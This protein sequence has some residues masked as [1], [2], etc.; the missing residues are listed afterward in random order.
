M[1]MELK[2]K[3]K[4]E[5]AAY[6][7][8]HV[9]KFKKYGGSAH[10]YCLS[11]QISRSTFQNWERKLRTAKTSCFVPVKVAAVSIPAESLRTPSSSRSLLPDA[12]WV[13]ELILC[14]Q[15]GAR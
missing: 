1:T 15:R 8:S 11:E 3:T 12:A 6:W 14:L 13:A 2:G 10:G 9:E 5:K 4:E 7:K